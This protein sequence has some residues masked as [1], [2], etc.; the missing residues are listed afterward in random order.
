MQKVLF[1]NLKIPN[2]S[3]LRVRIFQV[4]AKQIKVQGKH[5]F[6]CWRTMK[7][8]HGIKEKKTLGENS[9]WWGK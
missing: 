1:T 7:L 6:G 5:E 9:Q 8:V 4:V 3:A 2:K